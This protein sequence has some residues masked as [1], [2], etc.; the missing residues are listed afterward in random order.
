MTGLAV[1]P[2]VDVLDLVAGVVLP[3]LDRRAFEGRLVL[4][5][6]VAL[7]EQLGHDLQPAKLGERRRISQRF[8]GTSRHETTY[9]W[10]MGT[11]ARPAWEVR[12]DPEGA[13]MPPWTFGRGQWLSPSFQ[14]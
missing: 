4:S 5:D 14:Q 12:R 11:L 13:P 8:R 6:H 7:D 2:P 1:G 10:R 9:V 3:V